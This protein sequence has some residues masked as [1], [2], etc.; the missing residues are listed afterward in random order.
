M[1][2]P[3]PELID[4]GGTKTPRSKARDESRAK[5]DAE[6]SAAD[7]TPQEVAKDVDAEE[8][9]KYA[10][11]HPNK[12]EEDRDVQIGGASKTQTTGDEPPT[13]Q[14]AAAAEATAVD[15]KRTAEDESSGAVSRRR[16]EQERTKHKSNEDEEKGPAKQVRFDPD[17]QVPEPSQKVAKKTDSSAA[18]SSTTRPTESPERRHKGAVRRVVEAVELYD[19]EAT[20]EGF[21]LDEDS[22]E[23]TESKHGGICR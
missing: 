11:E 1:S 17:T 20:E 8:V 7:A 15:H 14:A 5:T 16:V 19:D 23:W 18:S 21:W 2:S 9:M 10:E 3:I 4:E 13:T 6:G 12:D 22:V